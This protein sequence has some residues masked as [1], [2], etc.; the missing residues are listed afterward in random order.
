M[1]FTN[2][3]IINIL[4]P[5]AKYF[6]LICYY[7]DLSLSFI[8]LT[9]STSANLVN[10][11][12]IAGFSNQPKLTLL[13]LNFCPLYFSKIFIKISSRIR[14]TQFVL[15]QNMD[16]LHCVSVRA[17]ILAVHS[18]LWSCK[19]ERT[20]LLTDIPSAICLKQN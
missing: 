11:S 8:T 3:S 7:P 19:S 14:V 20:T 12:S 1:T 18:S 2:L 16:T 5:Y 4:I 13:T 9:V 17:R 10:I 15:F 6:I